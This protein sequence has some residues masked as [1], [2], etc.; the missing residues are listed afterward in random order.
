MRYNKVVAFI[1]TVK[2][3]QEKGVKITIL[4]WNPDASKFSNSVS[5]VELIELLV[6]VGIEVILQEESCQRFAV[7]DNAIVWYGSMNLLGKEDIEDNIMRID[8]E[9]I[10]AEVLELGMT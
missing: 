6:D 4:T 1:R 5:K 3:L 10:A 8:S 7:I 2:A 9:D